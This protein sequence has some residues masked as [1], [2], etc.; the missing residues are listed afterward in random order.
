MHF[1]K[2][3][4]SFDFLIVDSSMTTHV[5]GSISVQTH[6]LIELIDT[7]MDVILKALSTVMN[8]NIRN[9]VFNVIKQLKMREYSK[10]TLTFYSIIIFM[11][12]SFQSFFR[13]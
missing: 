5:N 2:P 12:S 11:V 3:A 10:R 6:K 9:K 1:D 13:V 7:C 8:E 4:K